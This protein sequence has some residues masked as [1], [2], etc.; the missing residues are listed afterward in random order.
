MCTINDL[1]LVERL[2]DFG[3]LGNL[4]D[5]ELVMPFTFLCPRYKKNSIGGLHFS[6][7]LYKYIISLDTHAH[8]LFIYFFGAPTLELRQFCSPL[9]HLDAPVSNFSGTGP[10]QERSSTCKV[11]YLR[12]KYPHFCSVYLVSTHA[13]SFDRRDIMIIEFYD[14]SQKF[15]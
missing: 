13:V 9:S 7:C 14:R 12:S 3:D 1:D 2:C 10:N 8:T 5:I 4:T 11:C 15:D 6:V